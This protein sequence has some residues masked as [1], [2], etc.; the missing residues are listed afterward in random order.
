MPGRTPGA[1]RVGPNTA[2]AAQDRWPKRSHRNAAREEAHAS[3]A[4]GAPGDVPTN[5]GHT[6]RIARRGRCYARPVAEDPLLALVFGSAPVAPVPRL[7]RRLREAG[8]GW[9]SLVVAADGGADSALAFG[10]QPHVVVGDLDSIAPATLDQLRA[11]GTEIEAYPPDKDLT[12][13]EIALER[14]LRV[15]PREVLALGT[16]GGPR[17]DHGLANV[18][19]LVR[20]PGMVTLLDER[21]ECRLLR[22]GETLR[23][24]PEPGEV[25]SLLPLGGLAEGLATEGLRWHL[26]GETLSPGATRG[27]SNQ[28]RTDAATVLVRLDTGLVLVTRHFPD[29]GP[30]HPPGAD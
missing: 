26:A 16:L 19:L 3:L 24:T 18:L 25:V 21:N 14:A 5:V 29:T 23:W 22:G 30:Q 27:V 1:G 15:E 12:D 11:N 2:G 10:Y 20:L 13:G 28:P 7:V 17:L 6:P 9:R 4:S 8:R